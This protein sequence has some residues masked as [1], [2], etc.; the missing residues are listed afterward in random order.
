M[1]PT[2]KLL[3]N[4]DNAGRRTIKI[5]NASYKKTIPIYKRMNT[6]NLSNIHHLQTYLQ[7]TVFHTAIHGL[8]HGDMPSFA[9]QD[10]AVHNIVEKLLKTVLTTMWISTARSHGTYVLRISTGLWLENNQVFNSFMAKKD[11]NLLNLQHIALLLIN[12]FTAWHTV[13]S[14]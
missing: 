6:K 1:S 11:I 14:C 3:K 5:T 4:T 10:M 2:A 7:K 13:R 12:S 9:P 8:S